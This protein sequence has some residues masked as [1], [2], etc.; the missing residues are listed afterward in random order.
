MAMRGDRPCLRRAFGITLLLVPTLVAAQGTP[1]PLPTEPGGARPPIYTEPRFSPAQVQPPRVGPEGSATPATPA[2]SPQADAPAGAAT[3]GEA[4]A[5]QG[6]PR[7]P[8]VTSFPEL[9]RG[10]GGSEALL[11]P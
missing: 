1:L 9:T 4:K 5:E 3:S 6:K 11:K 8:Q 2:T 10:V 7:V